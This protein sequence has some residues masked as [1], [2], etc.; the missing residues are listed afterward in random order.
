MAERFTVGTL[1]GWPITAATMYDSRAQ[2]MKPTTIAYVYDSAFNYR[3]VKTFGPYGYR[4]RGSR[5]NKQAAE[6]F[7]AKLN[8][9]ERERYA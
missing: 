9:K 6:A 1:T 8:A 7:A 3:I 4:G 5:S 2:R